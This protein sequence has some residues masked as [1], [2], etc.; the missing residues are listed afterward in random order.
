MS[1]FFFLP[2]LL[3]GWSVLPAWAD[4]Y[5]CPDGK[6]GSVLRDVPCS[7]PPSEGQRPTPQAPENSQLTDWES[8]CKSFGM[9]AKAAAQARDRGGTYTELVAGLRN[10][11]A[12]A[13]HAR[14][15]EVFEPLYMAMIKEMYE[16][17]WMKPERAQHNM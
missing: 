5:K 14:L 1:L 8:M 15:R 10:G 3:L 9:T 16:K 17:S 2:L 12:T 11:L 7:L 13:S 4:V 6:G